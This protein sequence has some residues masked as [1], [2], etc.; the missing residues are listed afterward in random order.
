MLPDDVLKLLND[1][2]SARE[3]LASRIPARLGY[4][5][6]DGTPRVIPVAFHFTGDTFVFGSPVGSPKVEA[7]RR[8]AAVALTIDDDALPPVSLLVRGTASVRVVDG[9]APEYLA[10]N[11]RAMPPAA[12]QE[13]ERQALALYDRMAIIEIT[14]T[15]ARVFDFTDRV[16]QALAT[17]I[18]RQ[19]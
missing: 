5:A 2:P 4:I 10:A 11:R 17:L 14:P 15:W 12:W 9:V 19:A 18:E 3:L 16:P 7:L 1:D 13:F 8:N 6:A